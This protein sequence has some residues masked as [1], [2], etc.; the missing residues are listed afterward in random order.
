MSGVITSGVVTSVALL[1]GVVVLFCSVELV[2]V[3]AVVSAL[4]PVSV[5]VLLLLPVPALA[6]LES[7]PFDSALWLLS[8][9]SVE[10]DEPPPQATRNRLRLLAMAVRVIVADHIIKVPAG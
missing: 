5:D 9:L 8:G 2:L 10:P 3:S 1:S 4:V 7:L 6:A